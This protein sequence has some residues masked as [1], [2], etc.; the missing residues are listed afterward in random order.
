[1][2]IDP[3]AKF[4]MSI[5]PQVMLI[6]RAKSRYIEPRLMAVTTS[7]NG[8]LRSRSPVGC[9]AAVGRGGT[10]A[11]RLAKRGRWDPAGEVLRTGGVEQLLVGAGPLDDRAVHLDRLFLP[12][13][14]LA[15]GAGPLLAGDG[16]H[17]V[18]DLRAV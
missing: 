10:A 8:P 1:M 4:R 9:G 12:D 11:H 17:A 13:E 6:P 3:W 14:V 16:L 2:K 15:E 7:C 5:V 18:L